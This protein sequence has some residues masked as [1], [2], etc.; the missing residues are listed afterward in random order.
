MAAKKKAKAV[1]GSDLRKAMKGM[2]KAH[3]ELSLH[4]KSISKAMGG[5]FFAGDLPKGHTFTK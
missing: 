2:E 5:H 4:I 1:K 3:K